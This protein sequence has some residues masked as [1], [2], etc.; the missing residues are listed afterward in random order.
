VVAAKLGLGQHSQVLSLHK[1]RQHT[2]C[3]LTGLLVVRP[4]AAYCWDTLAGTGIL[5][6]LGCDNIQPVSNTPGRRSDTA[7]Q[8]LTLVVRSRCSCL[9]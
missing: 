8:A 6:G 9:P 4:L 5:Y 3:G 7:Q 2:V 1:T